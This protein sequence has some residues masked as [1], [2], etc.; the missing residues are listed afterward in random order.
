MK[1]VADKKMTLRAA[2]R[3]FGVARS[4]L[5]DHIKAGTSEVRA[6]GPRPV[7]PATVEKK[8]HQWILDRNEVHTPPTAREVR[9]KAKGIASTLAYDFERV[10][11][12]GWFRRFAERFPDLARRK[13]EYMESYRGKAMTSFRLNSF[14]GG[15]SVIASKV[16]PKDTYTLDETKAGAC[17]SM[18]QWVSSTACR[19]TPRLG[20]LHMTCLP[21]P[22]ARGDQGIEDCA[23]NRRARREDGVAHAVRQR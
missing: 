23:R 22:A 15:A 9:E 21:V 19:S 6:P 8:L 17:T 7:L 1:A 5:S 13:G 18:R 14:F 16:L 11:T 4:T 3:E 20:Q 12:E 2:A 10:G